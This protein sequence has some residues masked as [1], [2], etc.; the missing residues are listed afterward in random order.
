MSV[1]SILNLGEIII[2]SLIQILLKKE[3]KHLIKFNYLNR[4]MGLMKQIC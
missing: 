3:V 1:V 2:K 4:K